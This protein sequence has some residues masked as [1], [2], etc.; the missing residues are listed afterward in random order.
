MAEVDTAGNPPGTARFGG[1]LQNPRAIDQGALLLVDQ[2]AAPP[3]VLLSTSQALLRH[4]VSEALE[5]SGRVRVVATAG[6]AD[7]TVAHA[8]RHTPDVI[9]VFDD[10]EHGRYLDA[11]ANVVQRVPMCPVLVLV[12]NVDPEVLTQVI[13]LGAR[14]YVSRRAGLV[15][16]CQALE[17]IARG[18]VA[19]P[20]E[21]VRPLLEQLVRRRSEEKQDGE[22]LLQLSPREREVLS[23]LADGASSGGIAEAL[24]ITKETARKHVQNVLVKMGVQS[25]LAAVAYVMQGNRREVLR[26]HTAAVGVRAR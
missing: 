11:L 1:V 9:V 3:T 20:E 14:G 22:L 17:R 21:L 7:E 8:Q 4:T 2:E 16:L 5:Q 24:V 19:I 18:G 10:L 13:E 6:N 26:E 23:L 25:R 12:Q 15:E